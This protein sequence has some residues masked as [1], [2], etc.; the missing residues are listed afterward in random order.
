M[1]PFIVLE[2]TFKGHSRYS[3]VSSFVR[4]PQFSIGDQNSRL[5]LFSDKIAQVTLKVDQ[6]HWQRHIS[7]GHISLTAISGW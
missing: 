7:T 2:M 1:K 4:S 6:S 3:A 5:H